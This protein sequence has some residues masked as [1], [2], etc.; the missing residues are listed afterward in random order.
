MSGYTYD[1]LHA[2]LK[3]MGFDDELDRE[4]VDASATAVDLD[5][6]PF[7]VAFPRLNVFPTVVVAEAH[8]SE[9]RAIH[10]TLAVVE[11]MLS[12]AIGGPQYLPHASLAGFE[13]VSGY[14]RAVAFVER[15]R[16]LDV[17]PLRVDAVRLVELGPDENVGDGT[18]L[19]TYRL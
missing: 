10:D 3:L 9:L 11:G 1:D 19:R 7:T 17:P 4:A 14:D 15:G 6:G 13:T 16:D 2:T 18:V 5:I 12:F 8:A